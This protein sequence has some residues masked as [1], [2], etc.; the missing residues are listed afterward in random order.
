MP[1]MRGVATARITAA[2]QSVPVL[3]KTKLYRGDIVT[4]AGLQ[5]EVDAAAKAIGYADRPGK[6]TDLVFVGLGIFI[7]ALIGAITIHLGG[8]PVSLSTSGGALIAGL[9]FGW[10]RSKHPTFGGI[11]DSSVWLLN[12]LGP[13][14]FIAVIGITSAPSFVSGP[15]GSRLD[16]LRCRYIIYY[17]SIDNRRMGR[18]QNLQIPPRSQPWLLRRIARD[19]SLARRN[20]GIAQLVG[21]GIGIYYHLCNRQHLAHTNGRGHNADLLIAARTIDAGKRF[22]LIEYKQLQ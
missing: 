20:P 1:E 22:Y 10:L 3:A 6:S 7:G 9:I 15:E 5:R 16:A 13:N 4:I 17:P 12:N 21:T 14:M 11:P 2:G 18:R 8:I 19:H